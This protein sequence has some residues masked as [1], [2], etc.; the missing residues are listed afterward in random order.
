MLEIFF[1]CLPYA[2]D[3]NDQKGIPQ[4]LSLTRNSTIEQDLQHQFFEYL[5]THTK[6]SHIFGDLHNGFKLDEAMEAEDK[7]HMGSEF[8]QNTLFL[9]NDKVIVFGKCK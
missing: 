4:E 9:Q 7:H 3:T 8:E 6:D 5:Q 2:D 1:L